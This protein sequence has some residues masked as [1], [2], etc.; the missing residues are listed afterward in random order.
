M[1]RSDG[2]RP[3]A[4]SLINALTDWSR[5]KGVF[6]AKTVRLSNAAAAFSV[7]P[8]IVVNAPRSFS[9][10]ITVSANIL[11]TCKRPSA[12]ATL[13]IV[14]A[15]PPKDDSLFLLLFSIT[16]PVCLVVSPKPSV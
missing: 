1:A 8:V 16:S 10:S 9:V 15:M 2:S 4:F 14:A 5:V 12:A 6:D 7:L 13:P 3:S 11:P